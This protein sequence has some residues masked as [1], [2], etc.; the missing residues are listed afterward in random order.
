MIDPM[1]GG[2]IP[3][4]QPSEQPAGVHAPQPALDPGVVQ[5]LVLQIPDIAHRRVHVADVRLVRPGDHPLGNS[6][7]TGN[8][9]VIAA[10]VELL[11]GNRHQPEILAEVTAGERQALQECRLDPVPL[12]KIALQLIHEIDHG[13]DI[14]R[15]E[16]AQQL[17]QD[18]FRPGIRLQ[19]LM[20]DGNAQPRTPRGQ[21]RRRLIYRRPARPRQIMLM[22]VK[23]H[24]GAKFGIS[25]APVTDMGVNAGGHRPAFRCLA[26]SLGLNV[27][28]GHSCLG[29]ICT[30][31]RS[32][33]KTE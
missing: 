1:G 13:E 17:F 4:A 18:A 25:G 16:A 29:A 27:D 6:V 23:R 14:G 11:D 8:D 26:A 20:H 24:A 10:Q 5:I 30:S 12:Q 7:V 15:R 19:P 9:K 33:L 21:R 2:D 3:D 22:A 31:I 28:N 32:M